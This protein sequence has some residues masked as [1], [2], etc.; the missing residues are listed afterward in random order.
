MG[1]P[2]VVRGKPKMVFPEFNPLDHNHSLLLNLNFYNL[3]VET[4][5]KKEWTLD[6]WKSEKK[7]IVGL[8]RL[9]DGYFTTVGAVAHML[10]ARNIALEVSHLNFIERKY[11]E[12]M[13]QAKLL[14][15]DP[16]DS[17]VPEKTKE[18]KFADELRV[19]IAEFDHGMD[20]FFQGKT[21]D[22][23]AYILK[24]NIRTVMTKAISDYLKPKLKEVK[25]IAASKDEQLIE[26][27]SFLSKRQLDKYIQYVSIL[28]SS[29]DV[30]T[31]ISKAS[32]KPR[33]KKVKD[34]AT[35]VKS[36]KYLVSDELTKLK[37]EYPVKIIGAT[38][39]WLYHAKHRRL[40]RYVAL[41]GITLSVKGTTITGMDDSKSGGKIIRKPET[42][43]LGI[44]EM[45]TRPLNKIF[46]EI[47]GTTSKA[48]GRLN[49]DTIIVK[50]F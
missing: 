15:D 27:W 34:P 4:K 26:A 41:P 18:E 12:F 30:A 38:E 22:A 45:T 13:A 1:A 21:F 29:C 8:W 5:Q 49:S 44:G 2:A 17:K 37:S 47:K 19:H 3:E 11:K 35:L 20:M 9:P 48:V 32:R 23:K 14:L 39:V 7:S 25:N 24:H 6:Y 10:H 31:A 40:F 46:N 36:V 43:L 28:V 50:C 16:D 42:Q 33:A